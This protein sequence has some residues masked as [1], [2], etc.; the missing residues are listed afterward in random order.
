MSETKTLTL[1]VLPLDDDV[2]LPTMVVPLDAS[3]PEVRASI[4]AANAAAASADG[5][6]GP[7]LLLVPRIDGKYAPVGT[8]AVVEQEGRL[9]NGKP[10]AVLRGLARVRIGAGT[11]GPGAA[12]WVHG[13]IA[14][15]PEGGPRA[16]E[17][18]REYR[19][20][21]AAILQKRGA[22][23]VVDALS[24]IT[25][26]SALA[27]SAGYASY[28][29]VEQRSE[30]L[31]TIDPA[32]RLEKLVGWA[33]DHL[34]ELDVAETIGND[35]REG[36]EKQ[37]REFLLRQQLA[38]IRKELAALDG[39]PATEQDDYRARIEAAD[40]PENVREAALREAAKLERGS[41]ASPEAGWIRT[42]LDTILDVPWNTR[43]DDA[44][45]ISGARAVLDADHA[46]LDEV[47]ERIIEYL[48]VRKRL[49]DARHGRGRRAQ[50][51]CGAG[52]GRPARRR[53]DLPR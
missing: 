49:A 52:A 2:V 3:D 10:G 7:Q 35:V 40:L 42:W 32:Q 1:P 20:L 53:Q 16:A 33:R 31:N 44:Y 6:D 30:L 11:V 50:E 8:L 45:D 13:T 21:A 22:W 24:R 9:P 28:L 39:T 36:M 18:A 47:K 5:D 29:S 12:L 37:Q 27:D 17:L 26:P 14:D 43:T 23:Q 41:D 4:A 48:A 46:G 25:D 15:E 19:G 34:A 38:A 51:R